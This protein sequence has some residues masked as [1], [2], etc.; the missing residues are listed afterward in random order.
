MNSYAT[1]FI[2]LNDSIKKQVVKPKIS[3]LKLKYDSKE[4]ALKI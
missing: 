2:N 1:L 4:A 3:L